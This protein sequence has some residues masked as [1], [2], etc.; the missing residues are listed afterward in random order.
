MAYPSKLYS[1]LECYYD[2]EGQFYISLNAVSGIEDAENREGIY[3]NVLDLLREKFKGFPL[4]V[5]D[6]DYAS[7]RIPQ[8]YQHLVSSYL[9]GD[10]DKTSAETK[11]ILDEYEKQVA[12]N[13]KAWRTWSDTV[14]PQAA[15]ADG[16]VDLTNATTPPAATAGVPP[17]PPAKARTRITP[18]T[19][20]LTATAFLDDFITALADADA[21]AIPTKGDDPR[22]APL[23][24]AMATLADK[25]VDA[26]SIA[27]ERLSLLSALEQGTA[28]DRPARMLDYLKARI[29]DFSAVT[30]SK[31][32]KVTLNSELNGIRFS[33]SASGTARKSALDG[34]RAQALSEIIEMLLAHNTQDEHAITREKNSLTID[35]SALP[36]SMRPVFLKLDT[37][38]SGAAAFNL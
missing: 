23:I 21:S 20:P 33:V 19:A 29:N 25:S 10:K 3:R 7:I 5:T 31:Q 37:Q 4:T 24:T 18:A 1:Q 12:A 35:I 22:I 36:D 6:P 16:W 17:Q 27:E 38:K 32:H 14:R 8:E 13:Q 28:E 15:D 9:G 30:F 34:K 2:E 26:A 11:R